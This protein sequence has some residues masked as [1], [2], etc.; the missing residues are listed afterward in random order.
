MSY[1]INHIKKKDK[2]IT[3]NYKLNY[4]HTAVERNTNKKKTKKN[5]TISDKHSS[6]YHP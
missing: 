3:Y 1:K 5:K 2:V 6:E 4:L